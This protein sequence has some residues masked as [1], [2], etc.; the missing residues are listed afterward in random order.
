M[1][2]KKTHSREKEIRRVGGECAVLDKVVRLD[3][4]AKE[5]SKP[6]RKR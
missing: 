3:V 5:M 2:W 6:S 1:L 4:T